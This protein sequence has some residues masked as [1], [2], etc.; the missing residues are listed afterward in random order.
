M[1][2]I[3]SGKCDDL[4]MMLFITVMQDITRNNVR[5]KNRT[6]NDWERN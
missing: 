6:V 1:F 3:L 4:M 5:D 2:Q